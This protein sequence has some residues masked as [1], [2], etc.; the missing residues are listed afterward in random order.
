M[1]TQ[2]IPILPKIIKLNKS[3]AEL[4]RKRLP[5]GPP[6]GS[7]RAAG[8]KELRSY[9]FSRF[10]FLSFL[11]AL[12][13]DEYSCWAEDDGGCNDEVDGIDDGWVGEDFFFDG[14][15]DNGGWCDAP[16]EKWVD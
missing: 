12:S 8:G 14:D 9:F 6:E 10:V 4:S 1:A 3:F 11:N 2:T 5:E 13:V 7:Q 16:G 15:E